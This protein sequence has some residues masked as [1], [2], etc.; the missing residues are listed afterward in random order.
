MCFKVNAPG[1]NKI[2]NRN[3]NKANHDV[4][5]NKLLQILISV[6]GGGGLKVTR[7]ELEDTYNCFFGLT[8]FKYTC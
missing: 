5:D 3:L 8:Q 6:G 2:S 7:A 1:I 4:C